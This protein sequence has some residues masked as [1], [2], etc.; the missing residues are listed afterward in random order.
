V[1]WV[2]V[3]LRTGT[4]AASKVGTRAAFIKGNGSIVDVDG[5]SPVAFTNLAAGS[6]YLVVRHRNH[7]AVMSGS[8]VALSAS[9]TLYD[10]TTSQG[11]AYG[12]EPMKLVGTKYAM[13][14]GDGNKSGIVTAAD[15]NAVF[16]AINTPGYNA[17]DIN[18]SGI[19]TAADANIVFGNLNKATQ[20]P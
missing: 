10:F 17:N 20:V 12:T 6:Y 3:E 11:Q 19:V 1:D 7:L 18:L 4:S 8:A 5:V 14:A 2:L 9:S 16:G 13:Y 15:A